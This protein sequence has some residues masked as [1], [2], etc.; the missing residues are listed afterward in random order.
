[1]TLLPQPA[2]VLFVA[3]VQR[4]SRFYQAVGEMSLVHD[5]DDHVILETQGMQLVVHAK[6]CRATCG[7][8]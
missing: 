1:M 4:V 2:V 5:A 3:D 6:A 8:R 7:A